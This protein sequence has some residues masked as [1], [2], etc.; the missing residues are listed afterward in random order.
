VSDRNKT[1]SQNPKDRNK[2]KHTTFEKSR[3]QRR[4]LLRSV[5]RGMSSWVP[6][7]VWERRKKRDFTAAIEIASFDTLLVRLL[8]RACTTAT[9]TSPSQGRITSPPLGA[10]SVVWTR[11][12]SF[13]YCQKE[14]HLF[15]IS[16]LI[17]RTPWP[18][19]KLW[20][21]PRLHR[22]NSTIL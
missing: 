5:A 18:G 15:V 16:I 13:R 7:P 10:Y 9:P 22:V 6:N 14:I 21:N 2:Q 17:T 3:K 11:L 1:T 12:M 8:A 19:K 4:R 20:I